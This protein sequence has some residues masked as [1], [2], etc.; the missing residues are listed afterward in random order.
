VRINKL[1]AAVTLP[2]V[3]CGSIVLGTGVA[4]AAP[5]IVP[6]GVAPSMNL[7]DGQKVTLTITKFGNETS[8]VFAAV[9]TNK[10]AVSESSND[11]DIAKAVPGNVTNG[12]GTIK[13]FPV[14]AGSDY[15]DADG[16]KCSFKD[17]DCLV[18]VTDNLTPSN[19]NFAGAGGITFV[20][21]K[22]T[23][24]KV[25]AKSVKAGHKTKVIVQ[26]KKAGK[27]AAGSLRGKVILKDGAKT[28]GHKKENAKGK[29]TFRVKLHAGK[30]KLKAIYKGNKHFNGSNGRKTVVGKH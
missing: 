12:K 28:V 8:P 5:T 7:V 20:N 1:L 19:A 14:Q 3:M 25:K 9:C 18:V 21:P 30:N 17:N 13:N 29:V 24:T 23:A 10:V 6:L 15:A 4:S 26:T 16:G 2:A 27:A 22:K 11:C